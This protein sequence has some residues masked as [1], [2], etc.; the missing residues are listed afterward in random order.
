MPVK[1]TINI[2]GAGPAGLAAAIALRREGFPVRVFE[3]SSDVGHRFSGDFQGL[4]NWSSETDVCE[5]LKQAG[6]DINFHCTPVYGGLVFAPGAGAARA[7][8]GKPVVYL[9]RRGRTQ[10]S[11][12][13]G[14]KEQAVSLGAEVLFNRRMDSFD[15]SAIVAAGPRG[16][17]VIAAGMTF[18]TSMDDIA[19]MAFDDGIAPKGY[20]YLLVN[21][22]RGTLATVL[23]RDF[24]KAGE[25]FRKA[26]SFFERSTPLDVKDPKRFRGFGNFFIRNTQVVGNKLYVGESAGFQDGLFSFGMRYAMLS[27]W[28]AARSIVEGADYDS[29][30]KRRLLPAMESS[31][32]N[33]F[34]FEILGRWGYRYMA[35]RF[36]KED[37]RDFLM[38]QYNRGP[39]LRGML[40][41]L[42]RMSLRG[43]GARRDA[44]LRP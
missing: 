8:S 33:R 42:A 38:R 41:P 24:K 3:A 11:L 20:A 25:C 37:P 15:G 6:I 10:G 5:E 40:L 7:S 12:D 30:W 23:Y 13:Y 14:L 34:L 4:E 43:R 27:G 31:L 32:V 28:L 17:D 1:R 21:G 18:D 16:A 36:L 26:V 39:L 29:L 19:F 44:A 2:I 22:G 9:V 35:G